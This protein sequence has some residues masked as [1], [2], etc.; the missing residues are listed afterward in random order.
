MTP[1]FVVTL[2]PIVMQVEPVAE[3]VVI[4]RIGPI[5]EQQQETTPHDDQIENRR[6]PAKRSGHDR[7]AAMPAHVRGL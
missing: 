3:P 5:S 1:P 7:D 2:G 6:D 4:F